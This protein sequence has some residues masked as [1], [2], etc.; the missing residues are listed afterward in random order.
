[1]K[2]NKISFVLLL[3]VAA[4]VAFACNIYAE[5]NKLIDNEKEAVP[6]EKQERIIT[7]ERNFCYE[8]HMGLRGRLKEPGVEF[9]ES[10]HSMEGRQC[11][12]CHGGNPNLFDEKQAKSDRYNF[13]GKPA[14]SVIPSFCGRIECHSVAYFQFQK[15]AHFQS[16]KETGE[17]SC[18][19]CHGTHN[20][21]RSS[22]EV[23]SITACVGCHDIRYAREIINAVFEIEDEFKEIQ[24]SISFLE[25]KN[26]DVGEVVSKLSEIKGIFYQLVHVFSQDLMVFSKKII[27]LEAKALRDE[28]GKKVAMLK[29]I[30]LLYML[31][32]ITISII[33][34]IFI[35]Y[36][37][38]SNYKRKEK[39]GKGA[40]AL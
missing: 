19:T 7:Q 28:L 32:F 5:E 2:K 36:F 9:K 34:M 16:V 3:L 33:I 6:G 35:S 15:S 20:I 30:D 21:K 10:V 1:M 4:A 12:I 38:Y 40:E 8:C 24:K 26:I 31:T 14:D 37:L 23:M 17:P 29:R 25:S 39:Q 13:R 22:R 18:I 27:D 11:N